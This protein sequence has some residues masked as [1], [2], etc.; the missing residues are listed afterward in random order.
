MIVN[1]LTSIGVSF[2]IAFYF[3]W[4]LTLVIMCFLPLIGLSGVFQA[5][6]LTGFEGKN[7]K[8][9]EEAG[10]VRRER[11]MFLSVTELLKLDLDRLR[12]CPA[13]LS[14]TSGPSQAWARKST[15]WNHMKRS[16]NFRIDL[17]RREPTS[18]ACALVLPSASS[19]WRTPPPSHTE[20]IWLATRGYRTCLFSGRSKKGILSST[21]SVSE[22]LIHGKPSAPLLC[23]QGYFSCGH[24]RDR[25]GQSFLLHAGL[26]QSQNC[27]CS[28]LQS[29]G[30]SS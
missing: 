27:R 10:Q 2:I 21:E 9:M 1:S 6:M 7:K 15:L 30:P 12:R 3:S 25:A 29:A 14:P 19:S 8:S 23:L 5:K 16:S 20:A 26:C 18:T 4:K 11:G 17:L 28:V 22:M 13:R 24:Q